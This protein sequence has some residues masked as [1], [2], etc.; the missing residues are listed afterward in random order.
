MTGG[1]GSGTITRGFIHIPKSLKYNR[2]YIINNNASLSITLNFYLIKQLLSGLVKTGA[3]V[4]SSVSASALSWSS[5]SSLIDLSD[6]YSFAIGFT[7]RVSNTYGI[8]VDVFADPTGNDSSFSSSYTYQK[9]TER[10]WFMPVT[11][12]YVTNTVL[13]MR[14]VSDYVRLRIYNPDPYN[15]RSS[16]SLYS[17]I[18]RKT[19]A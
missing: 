5:E 8:C 12:S 6:A 1:A 14:I 4:L 13:P 2:V 15:T 19:G 9:P 17:I 10:A 18:Q 7:G 3:Q 11:G 16:L